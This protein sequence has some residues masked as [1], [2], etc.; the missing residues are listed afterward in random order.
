MT[1]EEVQ[2]G[3][4][5]LKRKSLRVE[6]EREKRRRRIKPARR[7]IQNEGIGRDLEKKINIRI[8]RKKK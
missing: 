4:D 1:K 2:E 6:G 3:E 5:V 7:M 8:I